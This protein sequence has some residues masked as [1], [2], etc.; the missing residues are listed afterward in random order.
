MIKKEYFPFILLAILT[1]I[2]HFFMKQGFGDDTYFGRVNSNL[3]V[4]LKQRYLSWSSR[5]LPEMLVYL[6]CKV[7][8]FIWMVFNTIVYT[9][10]GILLS[11][12]FVKTNKREMNYLV[13]GIML[14]YPYYHMGSAGWVTTSVFYLYPLF[15][16]LFC[17]LKTQKIMNN[18]KLSLYEYVLYFLSLLYATSTEQPAVILFLLFII[19]LTDMY[20]KKRQH[21]MVW[22]SLLVCVV[23]LV[24]IITCPGNKV[25]TIAETASWFPLYSE[26]S[27]F[28]KLNI[29]LYSTVLHFFA[30]YDIIFILFL[31]VMLLLMRRK[32]K[33]V[34]AALFFLPP[35]ICWLGLTFFNGLQRL[36][37]KGATVGTGISPFITGILDSVYRFSVPSKSLWLSCFSLA[38]IVFVIYAITLVF[39]KKKSIAMILILMLG[40]ASRILMGFSPTVYASGYRTYLYM[41]FAFMICTIISINT[42]LLRVFKKKYMTVLA[43]VACAVLYAV[44]IFCF[45]LFQG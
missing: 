37:I 44:N 17:V 6:A 31:F 40:F 5:M 39:D 41:Y 32:H 45:L 15:C 28:D 27:L 24:I 21:P 42:D 29:G 43:S 12:I 14:V 30:S 35:L 11:K 19:I 38:A 4:F 1:L 26:F 10:I 22:L 36:F 7:N 20:V 23:Q 16:L 34:K 18:K 25:R 9:S 2:M 3:L 8:F 13:C 33:T